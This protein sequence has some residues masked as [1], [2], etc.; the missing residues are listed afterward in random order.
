MAAWHAVVHVHNH[1]PNNT[2]IIFFLP[3]VTLIFKSKLTP[4]NTDEPLQPPTLEGKWKLNS[5]HLPPVPLSL[6]RVCPSFDD[7]FWTPHNEGFYL[8]NNSPYL[9]F[10]SYRFQHSTSTSI[11]FSKNGS[12][13]F[14][15]VKSAKN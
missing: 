14:T 1:L 7:A 8:F 10:D 13:F 3:V 12:R 5:S 2:R 11:C 9:H 6:S 15:K 4:S